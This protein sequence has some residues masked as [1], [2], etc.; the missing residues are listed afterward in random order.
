MLVD[1]PMSKEMIPVRMSICLFAVALGLIRSRER[2][3]MMDV[4]VFYNIFDLRQNS[5]QSPCGM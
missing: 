3:R 2:P 4:V 5:S 1:S